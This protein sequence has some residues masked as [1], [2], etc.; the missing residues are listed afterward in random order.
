MGAQH[1]QQAAQRVQDRIGFSPDP[2]VR[3]HNAYVVGFEIAATDAFD[4]DDYREGVAVHREA[5]EA[6]FQAGKAA[7]S[8]AWEQAR[9]WA[10]GRKP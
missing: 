7:R 2:G 4:W 9:E 1:R 5:F 10:A 6:G 3:A 8:K